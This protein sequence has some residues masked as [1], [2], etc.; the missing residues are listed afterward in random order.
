L[1]NEQDGNED[2]IDTVL[3]DADEDGELLTDGSDSDPTQ[4]SDMNTAQLDVVQEAIVLGE[5]PE[6]STFDKNKFLCQHLDDPPD[7]I[8]D[9]FK[10][11]LGDNFHQQKRPRVPVRHPY[12]KAYFVA[13][14]RAFLAWNPETLLE[15]NEKLM[16]KEWSEKDIKKT[17]FF[18]PA[19]FQSR[20][21]RVVP[22]PSKLYWRVR[23]V[24][25]KFGNK[26]DHKGKSLFNREAWRKANSVLKEILAGFASD[27][28]GFPMYTKKLRKNGEPWIDDYGIWLLECCRGTNDVENWHKQLRDTFG[29]WQIG[30]EM[31]FYMLAERRHRHNQRMSQL[32]RAGFPIVG[33][34]DSWKIDL[35]QLLVEENHGVR[36]FPYW[37]NS[38]DWKDTDESFDLVAMHD[39]ELQEEVLKV[40]LSEETISGFTPDLKFL[41]SKMGVK[42]AFLP[43]VGE[44]S[45][46]LFA[47]LIRDSDGP[48]DDRKMAVEWCHHVDGLKIFP[49]LPVYLR[50]YHERFLRNRRAED[51]CTDMQD[52]TAALERLNKT[53]LD[54]AVDET[55]AAFGGSASSILLD[56]PDEMPI[57]QAEPSP[58][59][60]FWQ[61]TSLPGPMLYPRCQA[62]RDSFEGPH[63]VG[64]TLIGLANTELLLPRPGT[65]GPD[66]P[67]KKKESGDC[68]VS[69]GKPEEWTSCKIARARE[70]LDTVSML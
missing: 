48:F 47:R 54:A 13:L 33:H 43:V 24:Y 51:A 28:P 58:R 38:G 68:A 16:K 70:V 8:T 19:F 34:Y 69:V 44:D 1:Q 66:K 23:A 6:S 35:L 2:D 17:M 37:V 7:E 40:E 30:V 59:I 29:T 36:L 14:M 20:A 55:E 31:T 45:E 53:T 26:K 52:E 9:C 4:Y 50:M 49:T 41:S 64:G 18:K 42:I 61:P 62:I 11:V 56:E 21:D 32:H 67:N 60:Q 57:E 27:P 46:R 22:S 5:T 39:D 10:A 3:L 12:K 25:V 15:V 63:V 65:R